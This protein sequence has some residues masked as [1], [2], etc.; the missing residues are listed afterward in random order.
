MLGGGSCSIHGG[1]KACQIFSLFFFFF[2][3]I[4]RGVDVCSL[5]ICSRARPFSGCGEGLKC[6]LFSTS[7]TLIEAS[8]NFYS[9]K[10]KPE[11]LNCGLQTYCVQFFFSLGECIKCI[12]IPRNLPSIT[13]PVRLSP[14]TK[15]CRTHQEDLLHRVLYTLCLDRISLKLLLVDSGFGLI[16]FGGGKLRLV[17]C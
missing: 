1:C 16:T 8:H 14:P 3:T 15:I 12:R 2:C 10:R 4:T 17:D 5:E 9:W 13:P 7:R 11:G 6:P